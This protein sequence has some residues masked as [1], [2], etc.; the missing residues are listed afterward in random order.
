[1]NIVGFL[2]LED[3]SL[4]VPGNAGL[5]D[6]VQALK[7]V[8]NNIRSF[9]GD[10]DNVTIFGESAGAASVHYLILSPLAKGKYLNQKFSWHFVVEIYSNPQKVIFSS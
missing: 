7:W 4:G 5:K 6:Q 2:S 9:S 10:P 8:Q 3:T 1:M